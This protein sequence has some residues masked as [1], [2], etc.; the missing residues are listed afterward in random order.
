MVG[1][2]GGG[3]LRARASLGSDEASCWQVRAF[4]R[5]A[6]FLGKLTRS[7]GPSA[8]GDRKLPLRGKPAQELLDLRRA[9]LARM[10]YV[11]ES[12]GAADPMDIMPFGS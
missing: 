3:S 5:V 10:G 1:S 7:Q 9:R 12:E 8:V 11:I 6:M 2:G 4:E